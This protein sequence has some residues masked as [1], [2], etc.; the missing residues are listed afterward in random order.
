MPPDR[1]SGFT[2]LLRCRSDRAQILRGG[3]AGPSISN[4]LERDLLSLVKPAH[5]GA[6]DCADVDE[7]VLA[8][9]IRLDEAEAFLVIEPLHGSLRHLAFLSVMC[10]QAASQRSQFVSRLEESRQSDAECAARPSRSAEA[11]L[12]QH[13]PLRLGVQGSRCEF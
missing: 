12:R 11:R 2:V 7:D 13:G 10:N 1:W 9:I 4:N 3:L 8:P 6:F 5:T